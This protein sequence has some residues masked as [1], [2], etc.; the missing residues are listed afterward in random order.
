MQ[1]ISEIALLNAQ[2]ATWQRPACLLRRISGLAKGGQFL[3]A[4]HGYLEHRCLFPQRSN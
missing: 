3:T 4:P 1:N 2:R